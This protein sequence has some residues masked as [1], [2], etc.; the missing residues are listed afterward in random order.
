MHQK[1][2]VVLRYSLHVGSANDDQGNPSRKI[3]FSEPKIPSARFS[4][5]LRPESA[6]STL[7]QKDNGVIQTLEI[8]RLSL[9]RA[10]PPTEISPS[11]DQNIRVFER[12]DYDIIEEKL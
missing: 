9:R 3:C 12:K 4:R 5:P 10:A 6:L 1:R 7:V 11:P 2:V 8:R